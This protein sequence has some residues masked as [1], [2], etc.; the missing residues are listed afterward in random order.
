LGFTTLP[1]QKPEQA[2]LESDAKLL[3]DL[4]T[5]LVETQVTEGQLVCGNCGHEYNIHQ[6]IANFLL[7]NHLGMLPLHDPRQPSRWMDKKLTTVGKV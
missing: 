3:Q 2:A 5:L 6:G 7:P 4:H 1:A